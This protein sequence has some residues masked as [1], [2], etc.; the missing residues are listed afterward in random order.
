MVKK[1]I[2]KFDEI[3]YWSEIKIEI[4]RKY[5]A[6]FSAIITAQ[7]AKGI[8]LKHV[9]IDGFSGAGEHISKATG[10]MVPGTPLVVL[11]VTPPFTEYHLIDLDERKTDHLRAVVGN[12]PDISIYTGDCNEVLTKRILPNV[13]FEQYKRGLCLLDPYGLHLDWDVVR[14]AGGTKAVEIFLN[15]PVT[16]MNRNVFWQNPEG[17]APDDVERMTAFWGDD[18]WRR[19][20]YTSMPTLFGDAVEMKTADN[21]MI[22]E[23]YRKR[24]KEIAGF[25]YVPEPIPMRNSKN[26]VVY[27]LFFASPNKT[28]AKIVEEIFDRYRNY[29]V[30]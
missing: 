26:A 27:Y 15:F 30:R 18:S 12:R 20:T 23:A 16:D 22:A 7:T 6:A 3:N 13:L 8:P 24:L 28:G 1:G 17:V 11:S 5:A 9:Y 14:M 25:E 10:E 21:Q 4:V 19:I 2:L 29:G